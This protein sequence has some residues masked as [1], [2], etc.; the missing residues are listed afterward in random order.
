LVP[1]LGGR[2]LAQRRGRLRAPETPLAAAADRAHPGARARGRV[3]RHAGREHSRAPF[4]PLRKGKGPAPVLEAQGEARG[5]G[6]LV[7]V[8]EPREPL[9]PA[10]RLLL[11]REVAGLLRVNERTVRR[12]IA[13]DGL[14][15]VRLGTRLRF[16][17]RNVLRWVSA[18][19][20]GS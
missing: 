17:E 10:P 20:E 9:V 12:W 1:P 3:R 11:L 4:P 19:E 14:P 18:R 16:S 15:C 13:S 6:G 7:V 5:G 8:S 2:V